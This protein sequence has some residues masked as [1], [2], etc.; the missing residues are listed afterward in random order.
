M[1][2]RYGASHVDGLYTVPNGSGTQFLDGMNEAIA[3]N[4][5][6]IRVYCTQDY[7]VRYDYQT[8]WSNMAAANITQLLQT[9][10][11]STL[12]NSA[13]TTF[14]FTTFA[15]GN[16]NNNWWRT[17]ITKTRLDT[18]YTEIYNAAVHLL[19]TYNNTGKTFVFSNWEG[20]WAFLDTFDPTVPISR[21]IVDNYATFHQIRQRAV[22]DARRNT[23]HQNVRVL[24][25]IEANRI[26]DIYS[27]PSYRRV[28]KDILPIIQPDA[29]AYSAYDSTI[30][31]GYGANQADWEA[32]CT[33]N[34]TKALK[35]IK[36]ACPG[37]P[38]FIGEFGFPENEIA[39]EHPGYDVK[40]MIRKV[41]SIAL[42]EGCEYFL[43]WQVFDN[44]PSGL[45]TY[46]GYWLK[47]PNGDTSQAGEQ[48][49]LFTLE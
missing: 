11:F 32:Q 27:N 18:E 4:L 42:S 47:K 25:V 20:D 38:I 33:E 1:V 14:Y 24:N 22:S 34:F 46:R 16:P 6:T 31:F 37:T 28:V 3:L 45:Y 49:N 17:G 41:Q 30:V 9:T 7:L 29:V 10:E 15:F 39:A 23:A 43:Y 12:I 36:N 40:A 26:S 5:S 19:T 44:E 13:L 8:A 2:M 35:A 48:M 21:Q